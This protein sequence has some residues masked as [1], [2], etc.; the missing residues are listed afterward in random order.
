MS[1]FVSTDEPDGD[2]W[3]VVPRTGSSASSSTAAVGSYTPRAN[4]FIIG[5]LDSS[6]QVACT[7]TAGSGYSLDFNVAIDLAPSIPINS[8]CS[9]VLGL[10]YGEYPIGCR[11]CTM[12]SYGSNHI[13]GM[14]MC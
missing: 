8:H 6:C 2:Q 12:K 4:A 5:A 13:R 10:S 1:A 3:M 14:R 7:I 9:P 11:P